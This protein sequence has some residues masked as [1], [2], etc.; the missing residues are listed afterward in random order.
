MKENTRRPLSR[1]AFMGNVGLVVA[2][3]ATPM[4]LRANEAAPRGLQ[5]W[6]IRHGESEINVP[7]APRPVPDAGMSYPLTLKGMDQ[8]RMLADRLADETLLAIHTSTHL[9]ALQTAD[10][11]AFRHSLTVSLAPEA[12]ELNLGIGDDEDTRAVYLDLARKWLIE[13]DVEARHRDGESFA[14]AQRRFLPFV[15]E[16]MNRHALDRGVIVIISH[17]ATLGFLTPVLANN[18]PADFALHHPLPN[19]GVIKT[20]LR[21]S[22]LFCTEWAGI[23]STQFDVKSSP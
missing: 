13:K 23:P 12:V 19:T 17:S 9:R 7:N 20:E 14:D 22:K 3:A 6:F 15:R 21:D 11:I 1:R 5:I 10:A 18:L 4:H 8:A 16:L 2:A